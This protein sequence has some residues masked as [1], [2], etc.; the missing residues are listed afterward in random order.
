MAADSKSLIATLHEVRLIDQADLPQVNNLQARFPDAKGLGAQLIRA[1]LL[2]PFQVNQLLKGRGADLVLG[3]YRLMDR[4]GEGGMG[5]VFKARHERLD[6][7]VA[8]KVIRK[9]KLADPAILERFRRETRAAAQLNHPNIVRALDADAIGP[10]HLLVMEYVEGPDLSQLVKRSGP[11]PVATACDYIR[12]AALG[13]QHAHE[14][15][16]IHRD[17]KPSNLIVTQA[18]GSQSAGLV[19]ILDMGLARLED[20]NG[21]ETSSATMTQTGSVVGTP[22]FIAPE[23][24]RSS[25]QTDGRSDIYSLGCTLYYLLTGQVPF[26]TGTLTEK[27]LHHVMDEPRPVEELRPDVPPEL[28]AII[29]KLMAKAPEKRYQRPAEVAAELEAWLRGGNRKSI[30]GFLRPI[31]QA[32]GRL[33]RRRLLIG[34]L[35]AAVALLV[36]SLLLFRSGTSAKNPALAQ[37]DRT[38]SS[39]PAVVTSPASE[40]ADPSG[41]WKWLRKFRRDAGSYEVTLRVGREGDRLIGLLQMGERRSVPVENLTFKNGIL[42]FTLTFSGKGGKQVIRHEGKLQGDTITGTRTT[43]FEDGR[44]HTHDWEASRVKQ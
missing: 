11:L 13:L 12:Q 29:R 9:D 41:T 23:Q 22:D 3:P 28:A 7:I 34:G 17:I 20:R 25:R 44:K 14:K 16:I 30:A 32:T 42:A 31:R 4:L 21:E 39:A 19:K 27:L 24:A 8:L 33:G 1:G 37:R 40:K 10:C 6:R 26:P 18:A 5:Q 2:T 35:A 38:I 43:E 15:G 36:A